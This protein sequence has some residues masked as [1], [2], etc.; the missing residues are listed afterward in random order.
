[1]VGEGRLVATLHITVEEVSD[2]SLDNTSG[3]SVE[4]PAIS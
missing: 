3:R 2:F 1:M 4:S